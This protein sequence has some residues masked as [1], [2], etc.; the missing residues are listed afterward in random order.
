MLL[1]FPHW[2]FKFSMI[3]SHQ[4]ACYPLCYC[5]C[6]VVALCARVVCILRER[7]PISHGCAR[8]SLCIPWCWTDPHVVCIFDTRCQTQLSYM[9]SGYFCAPCHRFDGCVFK[10]CERCF[11]LGVCEATLSGRHPSVCWW[12]LCR[13]HLS[14]VH[15]LLDTNSFFM[16]GNKSVCSRSLS[17]P[18]NQ[19]NCCWPE[20]KRWIVQ[21]YLWEVFFSS[22]FLFLLWEFSL[23]V[24]LKDGCMMWQHA[25]KHNS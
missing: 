24:V 8:G 22:L 3:S 12:T 21:K 23:V 10:T 6:C 20:Q 14:E 2:A 15:L 17:Q 4:S 18:I 1:K 5:F 25:H 11:N 16:H 13:K 7:T 19:S 9:L